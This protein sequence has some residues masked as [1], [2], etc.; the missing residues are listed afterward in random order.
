VFVSPWLVQRDP[1]LFP[2]PTSFR[3]ERWADD[4]VR[5]LPRFAYFPFGGGPRVC[6]GNAFAKME[7]VLLL[8]TIVQTTKL[9]LEP[10]SVGDPGLLPAITLRPRRT[11]RAVGWT[12]EE[13][14][15]PGGRA[16]VTDHGDEYHV[17]AMESDGGVF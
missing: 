3:P 5:G 12:S 6:I 2:E 15:G 11:I 7:A 14:A 8:A 13:N 10:E 16:Y 4:S 9:T 1:R 17:R